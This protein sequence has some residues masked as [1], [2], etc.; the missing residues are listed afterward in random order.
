MSLIEKSSIG[1]NVET[2]EYKIGAVLLSVTTDLRE[3]VKQPVSTK[4]FNM[5]LNKMN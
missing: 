1:L 2:P 3:T 5:I 4:L